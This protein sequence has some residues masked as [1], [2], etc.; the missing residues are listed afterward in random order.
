[1]LKPGGHVV[2]SVPFAM[3]EHEQP[4]DFYRYTSF[5]LKSLAADSGF[6]VKELDYVGDMVGVAASL[7]WRTGQ[8]ATRGLRRLRLTPLAWMVSYLLRI[9]E[10][11]YYA[12]LKTPLSP[13]R[14]AY[15]RTFPL[16]F[17]FLLQK[18]IHSETAP[19]IN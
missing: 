8:I 7:V 9:P 12:S 19:E 4:Y 5:A 2:A 14:F 15:F 16:G 3:R 18:P 6:V 11:I 13:S 1:V 17:T 10:L